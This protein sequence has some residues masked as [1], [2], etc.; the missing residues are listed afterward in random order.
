MAS[1]NH[2]LLCVGQRAG[3]GACFDGQIISNGKNVG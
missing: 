3:A 1:L 2:S